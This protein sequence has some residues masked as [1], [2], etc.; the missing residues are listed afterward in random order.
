MELSKK[1]LS[2]IEELKKMWQFEIIYNTSLKKY[3]PY[4]NYEKFKEAATKTFKILYEF[5]NESNLPKQIVSLVLAIQYFN[6]RAFRLDII[7]EYSEAASYVADAFCR[8]I[9]GEWKGNKDDIVSSDNFIVDYYITNDCTGIFDICN[10]PIDS[11]VFDLAV[12]IEIIK[13]VD[14]ANEERI[15]ENVKKGNCFL[16]NSFQLEDE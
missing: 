2:E 13:A 10:V 14:E 5:R 3:T 11:K 6:I 8:Q 1:A 16:E 15:L 9:V 12:L 7:N 4:F